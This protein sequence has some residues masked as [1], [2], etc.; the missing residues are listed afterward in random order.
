VVTAFFRGVRSLFGVAAVG[1]LFLVGSL[2]LRLYVLPVVYF[3][4]DQ[5]FPMVSRYMKWMVR[6]I[7]RL[8]VVG[9]ARVRRSGRVPTD[10]PVLVV[11]NHQSLLDIAQISILADPF[12]PAFVTRKRY[13][14][15]VPLVSA[16]LRLLGAPIIDPVREPKRALVRI[17]EA[18]RSLPHGLI[19]FP[20]SHRTR[21]GEV[22]HFYT[23]GLQLLLAEF[24]W[25]VYLVVN[26]GTWRVRRL[27]DMLFNLPL[28][29]AQS[30]VMGPFGP[31]REASEIPAFVEGL[32]QRIVGR[33]H[34][35][36]AAGLSDGAPGR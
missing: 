6:N 20:E 10:T 22:Q 33:L 24:A 1:G 12:V 16:S 13:A 32:R 3:R 5:R 8:L 31:P 27:S 18:A 17:K 19:I 7:C 9:G 23:S 21:D 29:D 11:A 2:V 30:E 26:E 25:P 36:R 4:P 35:M 34:E 28:M 15:F 14:R